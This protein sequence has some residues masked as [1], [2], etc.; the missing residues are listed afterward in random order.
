MGT[1][2]LPSNSGPTPTRWLKARSILPALARDQCALGLPEQPG[3]GGQK[4]SEGVYPADT[5]YEL[6]VERRQRHQHEQTSRYTRSCPPQLSDA[7]LWAERIY[8]A[9]RPRAERLHW[10][11]QNVREVYLEEQGV[12]GVGTSQQCPSGVQFYMF[13]RSEQP[14]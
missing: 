14:G 13:C 12:P 4:L 6:R 3:G 8:H 5:T 1:N 7:F 11:V 2:R 9:A 10:N